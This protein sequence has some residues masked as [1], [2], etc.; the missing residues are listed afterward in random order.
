MRL[1]FLPV[2][3]L[4]LGFN[5]FASNALPWERVPPE[6]ELADTNDLFGDDPTPGTP[7]DSPLVAIDTPLVDTGDVV[8]TPIDTPD[9]EDLVEIDTA[10]RNASEATTPPVTTPSGDISDGI[11]SVTTEQ[12]K[13]LLDEKRALFI[14]ARRADQF[15]KG[16]IPGSINIYAYEF[17]DNIPKI[18][19]VPKD[20]LILIY[21]DGGLC[22]L[23]HDLSEE[24]VQFGFKKIVIYQGGWEEWSATDYPKTGQ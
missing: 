10:E 8:E 21:C 9:V 23:S 2:I 13:R 3:L 6:M 14:D 19:S 11:K 24:L 22:E 1:L 7:I 20:R 15:E 5:L 17:A 4:T 18:M 12:A 16:H